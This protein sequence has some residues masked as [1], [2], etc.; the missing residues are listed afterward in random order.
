MPNSPGKDKF[1]ASIEAKLKERQ[2]NIHIEE[3]EI[4]GRTW[5]ITNGGSVTIL[6]GAFDANI[7]GGNVLSYVLSLVVPEE[8]ADFHD[9]LDATPGMD[10]EIL[11][12]IAN[13]MA[14]RIQGFPTESPS[15]S[16]RSSRT[17]RSTPR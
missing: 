15:A 6:L 9:V 13:E 2:K 16:S 17:P 14:E 10:A 5:H 11:L 7:G 1:A 3:M 4:L 8:Q 12:E